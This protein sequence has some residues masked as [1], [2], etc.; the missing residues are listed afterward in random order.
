MK[1]S[2][3]VISLY[4]AHAYVLAG[5]VSPKK[6]AQT[7]PGL[8]RRGNSQPSIGMLLLRPQS[9]NLKHTSRDLYNTGSY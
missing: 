2:R 7:K 5:S 8:G 6:Q 4:N 3:E 1:P 9:L